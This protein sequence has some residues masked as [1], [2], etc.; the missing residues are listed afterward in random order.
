MLYPVSKLETSC[1]LW[2]QY[3]CCGLGPW[4]R[5][6]RAEGHGP[7][8]CAPGW[9]LFPHWSREDRQYGEGI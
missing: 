3:P 6:E 5:L 4:A 2:A 1:A 7:R 9:H 8:P